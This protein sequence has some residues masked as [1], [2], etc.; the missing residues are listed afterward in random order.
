[1]QPKAK[2]IQFRQQKLIQFFLADPSTGPVQQK[3]YL[4][5]N[6]QVGKHNSTYS[7]GFSIQA[8]PVSSALL[9]PADKAVVVHTG[10]ISCSGWAYSGGSQNWIERVELSSDG[11]YFR[12]SYLFEHLVLLYDCSSYSNSY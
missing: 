8:M 2:L 6:Q 10:T 1:M 11:S 5:F 4:Y 7:R 12:I 9:F 3:E